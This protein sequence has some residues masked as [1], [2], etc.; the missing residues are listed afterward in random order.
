MGPKFADV[1]AEP[2]V[3]APLEAPND[4]QEGGAR[5]IDDR[6]GRAAASTARESASNAAG[7]ISIGK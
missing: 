5:V 1:L 6:H 3:I 2:S 7:R 4:G